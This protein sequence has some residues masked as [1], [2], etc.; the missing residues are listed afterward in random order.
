MIVFLVDP[1]AWFPMKYV[2]LGR[3]FDFATSATHFVE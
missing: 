3:I 2:N 1:E